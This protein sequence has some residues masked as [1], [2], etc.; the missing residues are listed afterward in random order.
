M[1]LK[2]LGQGCRMDCWA[3]VGI[4]VAGCRAGL[5]SHKSTTGTVGR[6]ALRP[7]EW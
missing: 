5:I 3:C 7:S 6:R 4:V 2:G 1:I